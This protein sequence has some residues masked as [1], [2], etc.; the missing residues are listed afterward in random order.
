MQL[1][2]MT[3]RHI[4]THIKSISYTLIPVTAYFE[5]FNNFAPLLPQCSH[6]EILLLVLAL[7]SKY[8]AIANIH[9]EKTYYHE[10]QT[11]SRF[12]LSLSRSR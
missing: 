2:T 3:V 6:K 7:N 9:I 5:L 8:L 10:K 11:F 12:R 4:H 1:V